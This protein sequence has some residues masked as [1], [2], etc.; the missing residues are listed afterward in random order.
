MNQKTSQDKWGE[1]VD[2]A[3]TGP[4]GSGGA[5]AP[6]ESDPSAPQERSD[7]AETLLQQAVEAARRDG[8]PDGDAAA[9]PAEESVPQATPP[10]LRIAELEAEV[11]GYKDQ[12]V[13]AHAEMENIR[14]RAEQ[15]IAKGKQRAISSFAKDILSVADNMDRA[16]KSLP[17]ESARGEQGAVIGNLIAGI[18]M[19]ARELSAVLARNGVKP[20]EAI[21]RVFDPNMHQVVQEIEDPSKPAG[22]IVQELQTG[23][24]L[25]DWLLRESMV[26][27]ARGGPKP[28]EEQPKSG[29]NLD[30]SA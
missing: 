20:I 1:A 17:D 12:Y 22:T 3:E 27:V 30:T 5:G 24:T 7:S 13:R 9:P 21:G 2:R 14:R 8:L 15:D 6:G 26:V 19:T 28:G 4:A 18:E 25:N 16:L 10:S 29:S 23:Y 11:A